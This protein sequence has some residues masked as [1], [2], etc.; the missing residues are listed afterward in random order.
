M[1]R[2][3][4]KSYEEG[5]PRALTYPDKTLNDLLIDSARQHPRRIATHYVLKY[6][7]KDQVAIGGQITYQKLERYVAAFAGALQQLG[8]KQG[9]RVIV[10]LP[11]TPHYVIAFFG[12]LRIGAIVV[13]SNPLY[14]AAELKHQIDDSGAETIVTLDRN[15]PRINEIFGQTKLKRVIIVRLY[16]TLRAPMKRLVMENFRKSDPPPDIPLARS[17]YYF[18][19]LLDT[20]E[21]V[22]VQ[23]DLKP[24]DVALLQYTGGTTGV[25]KRPC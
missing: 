4:Y 8:V 12:A 9:D 6:I 1:D 25:P 20:Y 16:D 13:N 5:M 10:N 15:W 11:N 14:T 3:W 18:Q 17:I 22:K 7:A 23:V 21:P 19:S 2:I 24:D